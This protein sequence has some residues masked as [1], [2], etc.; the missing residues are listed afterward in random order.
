MKNENLQIKLYKAFYLELP[1]VIQQNNKILNC[2]V[3]LCYHLQQNIKQQKNKI[4][5][6]GRYIIKNNT[7]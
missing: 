3:F 4:R 5:K 2:I 7:S 6:R 1:P